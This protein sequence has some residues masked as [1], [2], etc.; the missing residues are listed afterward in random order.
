[1][2]RKTGL[3]GEVRSRGLVRLTRLELTAQAIDTD[4]RKRPA[5]ALCGRRMDN[6]GTYAALPQL[7]NSRREGVTKPALR[8]ALL[9]Q[10]L[11]THDPP[12]FRPRLTSIFA[13]SARLIKRINNRRW[14]FEN[15]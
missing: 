5:C 2:G 3:V 15:L 8:T 12:P 10:L 9:R 4:K 6:R 14:S 11:V 1:M 13:K 7:L